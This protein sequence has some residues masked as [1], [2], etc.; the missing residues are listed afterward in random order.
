MIKLPTHASLRQRLLV[1]GLALLAPSSWAEWPMHR[2]DPELSG[3]AKGTLSATPSLLWSFDSKAAIT[4]SVVV[5]NGKAVFGNDDGVI[6]AVDADT[7]KV[8]WT[9]NTEDM[10]ESTPLI[11]GDTAYVGAGNGFLYA[12][13]LTTGKERWKFETM[14]EIPGAP[15]Y[16]KRGS[17]TWILVGSHDF[18]LYAID[19][20]TGKEVW[21]YETENF[22]NG[23]PAISA[24]GKIL[25]GGCDEFLHVVNAHTGEGEGK[26][27]VGN[28]IAGSVATQ[29]GNVYLGHYGSEVICADIASK[30]VEWTFKKRDFPFY[31]T[32]AIAN[33]KIVIGG[34]DKRMHCLD[35]KTG[36][37]FW[38]F[39]TKGQIDSSA[40]I[41]D[42]KV[43]FGSS[44]GNM[45]IL[46]L[47]D[48]SEIWSFEIGDEIISSPAVTDGKI[49]IGCI[50]GSVYCFA[51]SV[52][53]K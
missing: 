8:A 37:Q 44:D 23:I 41:C 16:L 6:Y 38:E 31:A 49:F 5:K 50:D 12:L 45:F 30:K 18:F 53:K 25:F 47:L 26:I 7:G 34:R 21:K 11:L 51:A 24:E 1:L 20:K 35:Q 52:E 19:A 39:R 32:P 14:G 17:N 13:D 40:V 43:V 10:I 3:F 15:N 29:G 36:E 33:G 22:I 2:G 46:N 27:G 4:G 42:G 28:P 48:G 9:N